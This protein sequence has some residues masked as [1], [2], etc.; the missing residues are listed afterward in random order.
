MIKAKSNKLLPGFPNFID[1]SKK[2]RRN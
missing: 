1:E 2:Y